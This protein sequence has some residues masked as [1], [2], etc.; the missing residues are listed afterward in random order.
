[1]KLLRPFVTSNYGDL[2]LFNLK[3][4]KN[5]Q[6]KTVR[7]LFTLAMVSCVVLA[8]WLPI[9]IVTGQNDKLYK[10]ML[11]DKGFKAFKYPRTGWGPGT[12]FGKVGNVDEQL[13]STAQTCFPDTDFN[14]QEVAFF[15]RKKDSNLSLGA[16][17]NFLP[18]GDLKS[19]FGYSRI[20][21]LDVSFGPTKEIG[22]TV[23]DLYTRLEN[24]TI[25]KKCLVYL[26]RKGNRIIL[27]IARPESMEY[28]FH[29]DRVINASFSMEKL[30]QIMDANAKLGFTTNQDDT[31]SI[32][33]PMAIAYKAIKLED[34]GLPIP[35]AA[36]DDTP[37]KL[38]KG[39][40]R[41][42]PV[43]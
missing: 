35:N 25:L 3:G 38:E 24:K 1:M 13:F 37:V 16:A 11:K 12:I 14:V 33:T 9:A 10:D 28:K 20:R 31:L 8:L 41:L 5:M 27:S 18:L 42:R 23:D 7:I 21:K 36:G 26:R 43:Q 6:R 17:F 4:D 39:K 19:A 29:G 34:L 30:K 2:G 15:D 22:M 40:F 32:T